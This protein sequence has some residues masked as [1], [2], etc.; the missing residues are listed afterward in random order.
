MQATTTYSTF[1]NQVVPAA[2][3]AT[4][5]Y[6]LKVARAIE[7][8]WFRNSQGVGYRSVSYTHLTLPTKA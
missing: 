2:E 1:P 7:G 4:Y 6:G 3:K 5:E 8:E